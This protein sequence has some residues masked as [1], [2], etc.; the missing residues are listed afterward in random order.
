MV[1]ISKITAASSVEGALLVDKTSG[2]TS[3]DVV[4][5]IRRTFGIKKVGHCGTLDPNATGLLILLLGKATKLSDRLMGDD[6]VYSG[7][8]KLGETTDS[9]DLEGELTG[10]GAVPELCIEDLN[11]FAKKFHGDQQQVPPMVSAI[12]KNGVPLYKLARKGIEIKREP[13]LVHIYAFR[14]NH[15]EEPSARFK[16]ACSK[17][18][19]I[20]SLI[21]DLGNQVGCGAHLTE[22]RRL[23]SG[24]FKI[25]GAVPYEDILKTPPSGLKEL[26]VPIP[27]LIGL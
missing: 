26:V 5:A 25:E 18:T 22:L 15:Y 10:T 3:H 12:K 4:A 2:P 14:F 24:D 9:Y 7:R 27:R 13:R 23:V 17:G 16:V 19:Y 8:M 20:R 21:H 1:K 11:E 6:K